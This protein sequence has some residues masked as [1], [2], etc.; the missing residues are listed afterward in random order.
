MN[1][2]DILRPYQREAL[3]ALWK[4][5]NA[6]GTRVAIVMATGLGKTKVFTRAAYSW[7]QDR[8]EIGVAGG[9]AHRVLVIAHTDELIEQAAREM[10]LACPGYSVGIVKAGLNEAHARIIVSS[11]QTLATEKRRAQVRNV[12]LIIVDECHH[13]LRTNTYGKILEYFGAFD[14]NCIDC[15]NHPHVKVLGVTATLARGDKRKLSTV[16]EEVAFKR[17]ILFGIRKGFLLDVRGERVTVPGMDLKGVKQSGGDY[18]ES[19]LAEEMERTYAPQIVAEKY[20]T[21][22]KSKGAGHRQGIAFWPLVDTA[23]HG[24]E[25]FEAVGI[26]SAVVHGGLPKEERKLILKRFRAGEITVVHNCMVLTEG[27]DAPWADVV[28]IGRPTRNEA[29]YQQMVGRVLRPNLDIP[30]ELREKAL[31]LDVTGAGADN[32][33]RSLIDLSPERP[34][35][36]DEDGELSL[37]ELDDALFEFEE[38]NSG[39]SVTLDDGPAYDGETVTVAFDPLHRE[40]LWAQTPGGTHY[41]TAGGAH[42]V[43]LF[44]AEPALYDVI[45]CEKRGRGAGREYQGLSLEDAL[46]YG[47]DLAYEKGG[48]GSKTLAKRNAPWRKAA[49]EIGGSQHKLA[50]RL[51]VWRDGMTKGECSAAID[52]HNAAS[53]IDPRVRAVRAKL[54]G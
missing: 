30:A 49:V 37:L 39:G 50:K 53:A 20:A 36:R 44:E 23:Y 11:R 5:W 31:V 18:Q 40:S 24:A 43:F 2:M 45:W 42:Y 8:D 9:G 17:D 52:A 28:V 1:P 3:E 26:P 19:A 51:G 22:A 29:L 46:T 35:K 14:D 10:R 27:F 4:S 15:G 7:L 21:V 25:A 54:E 13:A 41:M 6:G 48:V 47:E 34:L 38:I 33:L 32:T 16:W 12:G